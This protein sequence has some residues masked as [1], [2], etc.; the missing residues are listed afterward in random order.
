ML[1]AKPS[2][3]EVSFDLLALMRTKTG[4]IIHPNTRNTLH[5]RGPNSPVYPP[6]DET[7]E[8]ER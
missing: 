3:R 1:S 8:I 4:A 2:K 6:A 7:E 5:R